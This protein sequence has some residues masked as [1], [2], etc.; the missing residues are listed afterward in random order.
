MI[1]RVRQFQVAATIDYKPVTKVDSNKSKSRKKA[2]AKNVEIDIEKQAAMQSQDPI[3]VEALMMP[4]IG[5]KFSPRSKKIQ[6]SQGVAM[7]RCRYSTDKYGMN[8]GVIK[9]Y[10]TD[11]TS[12]GSYVA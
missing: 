10:K 7:L 5:S 9:E 12:Q 2:F 8:D 6:N 1:G 11:F 3:V 4:T